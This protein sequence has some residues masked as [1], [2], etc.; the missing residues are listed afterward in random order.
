MKCFNREYDP[1]EWCL[2][3][4]SSETSIKAVLLHNGNSFES[5]PLGHSVHLDE[6]YKDLSMILEK[7]NY[8]EHRW[9]FCGCWVSRQVRQNIPASYA[10]GAVEPETSIGPTLTGHFEVP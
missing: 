8:Q 10:L 9:M 6:N 3:I 1:Y 2:F 4:D 5:L 7:I